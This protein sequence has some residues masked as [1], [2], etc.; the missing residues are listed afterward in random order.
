MYNDDKRYKVINRVATPIQLD[1]NG[2]VIEQDQ[3]QN[4]NVNDIN[5][6]VVKPVVVK[7]KVSLKSI[8]KVLIGVFVLGIIVMSFFLLVPLNKGKVTYN[9]YTTKKIDNGVNRYESVALGEGEYLS[10]GEYQVSGISLKL[11]GN[12]IFVNN[13]NVANHTFLDPSVSVVGD[14]LVFTASDNSMSKVL[15]AVTSKGEKILAKDSFSG[16]KV[17]FI[18]SVVYNLDSMVITEKKVM[19]D[20]VKLDDG[21]FTSICAEG[22]NN[23]D[24]AVVRYALVYNGNHDFD[25]ELLDEQSIGNYKEVNGYCGQE[26]LMKFLFKL[27]LNL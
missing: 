27:A 23:D 24:K 19:N 9:D 12:S 2:N 25:V 20:E 10:D 14:V 15:Y 22:V 4:Q 6:S 17:M 18:D 16:D 3:Q 21:G 7:K 5:K 8:L 13:I 26:E 1:K 11:S